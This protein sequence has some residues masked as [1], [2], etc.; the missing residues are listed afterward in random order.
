M[1]ID[2]YNS[3]LESS[4]RDTI[5]ISAFPGSGKSHLFRNKG[6]RIILDSDSS[7]FDKSDF[8]ANYLEHIKSNIGKA[9]IILVS[10]HKEIREALFINNINY[11]LVYPDL[12]IKEEYIQRYKD[13]GSDENFVNLL[14]ENWEN[15]INELNE[16]KGCS[17]IV[18]KE[19]QYLS[20]VI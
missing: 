19:N 18:L 2:N 16:Q 11:Q 13:R 17:K 5:I 8:P 7:K 14:S 12:S 9:D 1:K 20:D 10:S 15:W 6:D 4:P 3:F